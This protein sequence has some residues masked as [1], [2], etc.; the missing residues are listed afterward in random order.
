MSEGVPVGTSLREAE[1]DEP[2]VARRVEHNILWLQVAASRRASAAQHSTAQHS[3]AQHRITSHPARRVGKG[4]SISRCQRVSVTCDSTQRWREW[5]RCGE[6]GST[7]VLLNLCLCVS[8]CLCVVPVDDV[9]VVD[10]VKDPHDL[11]R[12]RARRVVREPRLEPEQGEELPCSRERASE[13]EKFQELI[14][15]ERKAPT[16]KR[17]LCVRTAVEKLQSEV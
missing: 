3:T 16:I 11:R 5:G 10:V 6:A 17:R 1:V 4:E 12:Q 15:L 9:F 7:L 8:R 2:H 14:H 13:R